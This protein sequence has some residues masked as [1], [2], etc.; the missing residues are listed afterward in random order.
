MKPIFE[1]NS[2]LKGV[3]MHFCREDLFL[4]LQTVPTMYVN[5]AFHLGLHCLQKYKNT[6]LRVS[7]MKKGHQQYILGLR[8][9]LMLIWT[10]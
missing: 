8:Y 3:M 5:A 2:V 7:R 1:L 10:C 6:C 4:S 9:L